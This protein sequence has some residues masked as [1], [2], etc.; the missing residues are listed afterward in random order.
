MDHEPEFDRPM[1]VYIQGEKFSL[2]IDAGYSS[3]HVKKFYE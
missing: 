2:A 1:L 3:S